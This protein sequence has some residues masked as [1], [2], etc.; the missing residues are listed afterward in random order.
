M[1]FPSVGFVIIWSLLLA[2]G[3]IL[4]FSAAAS[5][6]SEK[7]LGLDIALLI[8]RTLHKLMEFVLLNIKHTFHLAGRPMTASLDGLCLA[9]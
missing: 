5:H 6:F 8:T 2:V 3:T 4:A 1:V 7:K 9:I